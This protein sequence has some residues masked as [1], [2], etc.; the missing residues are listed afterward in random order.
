MCNSAIVNCSLQLHRASISSWLKGR[1][2]EMMHELEWQVSSVTVR[3][4]SGTKKASQIQHI[5]VFAALTTP[6]KTM[7]MSLH[8]L[9][10]VITLYDHHRP[11]YMIY[12][13]KHVLQYCEWG[14]ATGDL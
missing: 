12:M 8:L 14:E 9:A 4:Q 13:I 2:S 10:V 1:N 5:T 3:S 11:Y 7:S 6:L